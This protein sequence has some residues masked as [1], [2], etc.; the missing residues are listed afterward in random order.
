MA[1]AVWR[2]EAISRA[3]HSSFTS[4][5]KKPGQLAPNLDAYGH[6]RNRAFRLLTHYVDTDRSEAFRWLLMMY[7]AA[8]R[9]TRIPL[10]DN[11]FHWG[12]L[13]LTSAGGTFMSKNK[14]RSLAVLMKRA[15]AEGLSEA[16]F[17]TF[18]Q[19]ERRLQAYGESGRQSRRSIS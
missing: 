15:H 12:L 18:V 8:P 5:L 1:F 10:S 9:K 4:K 19:H 7:G 16:D 17:E 2:F 3:I 6:F 14:L 11:P 13:A